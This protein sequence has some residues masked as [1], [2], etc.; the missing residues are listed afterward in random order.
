MDYVD[1]LNFG[2][3]KE[4]EH[5]LELLQ[6]GKIIS[7]VCVKFDLANHYGIKGKDEELDEKLGR[8]LYNNIRVKRTEN[9]G[10]KLTVWDTDPKYASDI[11]N[12]FVD[13]L[14]ALRTEMKQI[15]MDSIC[16]AIGRSKER[17][18]KE[19]VIL[20]DSM[21]ALSGKYKIY[22]PEVTA[23]R[24]AQE[25]AKQ[26]AAGNN[27]AIARLDE[28]FKNLQEGGAMI[29][30]IKEQLSNKRITLK[31]WNEYL[32]KATV[33]AQANVPTEFVVEYAY[34]TY[35]KDKPKR[36][37]I[38]LFSAICC[39]LLA[40]AVLVIRDKSKAVKSGENEL[41]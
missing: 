22:D 36:S 34:P 32:E 39:T 4:S 1:P 31:S 24:Y 23:E 13:R 14:T 37:I 25:L 27:A 16:V 28:R 7:E 15:K 35:Y 18:N 10:I 40:T 26:V 41:A 17:I 33:D 11:A 2:K 6:S 12:Y 3:E 20:M 30:N 29:D 38:T 21:S 9:L 5:V 8:K 19:I